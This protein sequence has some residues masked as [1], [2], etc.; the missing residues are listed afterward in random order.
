MMICDMFDEDDN[1][2]DGWLGDNIDELMKEIKERTERGEVV[3]VMF[4]QETVTKN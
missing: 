1:F 3:K 4:M 2:V